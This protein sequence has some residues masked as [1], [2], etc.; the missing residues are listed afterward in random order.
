MELLVLKHLLQMSYLVQSGVF[1]GK[2][3]LATCTMA[4]LV[5][6]VIH[7]HKGITIRNKSPR[8]P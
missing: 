3:I 2:N 8:L 5:V 4:P 1:V 6:V 7:K